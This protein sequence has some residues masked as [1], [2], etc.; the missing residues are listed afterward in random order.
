[1]FK[2]NCY[3]K[4][5]KSL[6][7]ARQRYRKMKKLILSLIL[8]IA[9][10]PQTLWA[11]IPPIGPDGGPINSF[12]DE[13]GMIFDYQIT[14]G[15]MLTK[16]WITADGHVIPTL[17]AIE[18]VPHQMRLALFYGIS[19]HSHEVTENASL[20]MPA[21]RMLEDGGYV[22]AY[23]LQFD[24]ENSELYFA[25]YDK[26]AR[27]IDHV[28]VGKEYENRLLWQGGLEAG[29]ELSDYTSITADFLPPDSIRVRSGAII[30]IQ[31]RDR[32]SDKN[33]VINGELNFLY[34]L[35]SNKR[36]KL[37]EIV[38][39][40][41][42]KADVAVK[43]MLCVAHMP[44]SEF[45]ATMPAWNA[46]AHK[47]IPNTEVAGNLNETQKFCILLNQ[48]LFYRDPQGYMKWIYDNRKTEKLSQVLIVTARRCENPE[49]FSEL[50]TRII[51]K[52]TNSKEKQFWTKWLKKLK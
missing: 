29:K 34:T 7:N 32:R 11:Y 3:D 4:S 51:N 44:A 37:I 38:D 25:S 9:L 31:E 47:I 42:G 5:F 36:F 39:S 20:F 50:I 22:I 13:P 23:L 48:A 18:H 24:E 16:K 19:I 41:T 2:P 21:A 33:Y 49:F 46:V 52:K 14:K 27:L 8:A 15:S 10:F 43:D 26:D 1:M 12:V 30:G 35:T 17:M 6:N 40:V 28:Y 45:D